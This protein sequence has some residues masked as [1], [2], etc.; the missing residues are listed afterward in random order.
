METDEQCDDLNRSQSAKTKSNRQKNEVN[1]EST[2]INK[3]HRRRKKQ[4]YNAI[5]KQMEFYFSDANL[6]KDRFLKKLI[7]DDPCNYNNII[8]CN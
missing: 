7:A 6:S 2:L 3:H 8:Q 4:Y 1:N 5:R